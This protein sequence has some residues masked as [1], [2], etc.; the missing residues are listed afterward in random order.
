MPSSQGNHFSPCGHEPLRS[1]CLLLGIR[2]SHQGT[3]RYLAVEFP[4]L[5]SPV[6]RVLMVL[7]RSP[8]PFSLSGSVTV[9]VST[10]F[11]QL[12]LG[13]VLF[14][15]SSPFLCPSLQKQLPTFHSF[16][17]HWFTSMYHVPAEFCGSSYTDC[18]VNP[19]INFLGMQNG[20]VLI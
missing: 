5:L 1:H 8:F 20:L 17:L 10:L 16:S 14:L 19:Q 18:W 9:G 4:T 13:G 12:L 6:Y 3:A 2:P 11:L 7:K 15:H